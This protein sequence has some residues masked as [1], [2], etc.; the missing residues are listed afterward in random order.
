MNLRFKAFRATDGQQLTDAVNVWL[1]EYSQVNILIE[2][3]QY[4][5]APGTPLTSNGHIPPAVWMLLW[6]KER[7]AAFQ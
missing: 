7:G 4:L 6:Y 3:K 1:A 5:V 2:E